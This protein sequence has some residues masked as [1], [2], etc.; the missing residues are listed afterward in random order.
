MLMMTYQSRYVLHNVSLNHCSLAL[1]GCTFMC[2]HNSTSGVLATLCQLQG[3]IN[4]DPTD[5]GG[6]DERSTEVD[7]KRY[8]DLR[9]LSI[10][11]NF[12]VL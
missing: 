9:L 10:C 2:L 4:Q 3:W 7:L 5:I 8:G 6:S 1:S 11:C 12:A